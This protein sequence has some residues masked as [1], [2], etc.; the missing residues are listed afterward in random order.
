MKTPDEKRHEIYMMFKAV[1]S[2]V[3]DEKLVEAL[4]LLPEDKIDEMLMR[5]R[6]VKAW[7]MGKVGNA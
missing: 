6:I 2:P 5:M 3:A 1:G 4:A 7:A